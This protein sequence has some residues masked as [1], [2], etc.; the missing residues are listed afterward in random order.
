[1]WRHPLGRSGGYARGAA[2]RALR[3]S[4]PRLGAVAAF[5]MRGTAHFEASRT[6]SARRRARARSG[7][8]CRRSVA[9]CSGMPETG[10]FFASDPHSGR[11]PVLQG[12]ENV[13]PRLGG[14]RAPRHVAV[15]ARMRMCRVNSATARIGGAPQRLSGALQ[16]TRV[17]RRSSGTVLSV[18]ASEKGW[19]C[20]A[21]PAPARSR[22]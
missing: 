19:T 18:L 12:D 7:A 15:D 14:R 10:R 2:S 20:A 9:R 1:M 22:G 13:R 4:G 3:S 11:N 6:E 16:N 21:R 17:P 5:S 8:P